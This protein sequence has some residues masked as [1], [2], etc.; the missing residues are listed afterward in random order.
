MG[1]T[2]PHDIIIKDVIADAF[3]QQILTRP[4]AVVFQ[5]AKVPLMT[6]YAVH[7][8]ITATGKYIFRTAV[9]SLVEGAAAVWTVSKLLKMKKVA[10]ITMD[11]D[12]G[13][14]LADG[15]KKMAKSFGVDVVTEEKYSLKDKDLRPLLNRI[16]GMDVDVIYANGFYAQ[17]AMIVNQNWLR[18]WTRLSF[19][20]TV[21]CWRSG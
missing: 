10:L 14:A 9:P 15:F 6:A 3:L 8:D 20:W 11:N 1:D 13:A 5:R 12:A 21:L 7:P 16:K 2:V 19:R 17:A 18:I 4:A